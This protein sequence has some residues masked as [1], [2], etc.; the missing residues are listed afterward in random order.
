MKK[1][2]APSQKNQKKPGITLLSSIVVSGIILTLV[3]SFMQIILKDI[4]LNADFFEGEKSYFAAESGIEHGLLALKT[5]P[6]QNINQTIELQAATAQINVDNITTSEVLTI[7]SLGNVKLSL[8]IAKG[9][10]FFPVELKNLQATISKEVGA[11]AVPKKNVI[12]WKLQCRQENQTISIQGTQDRSEIAQNVFDWRGIYDTPTEKKK[13]YRLGVFW[14]NLS[15]DSVVQ[16][17]CFLSFQNLIDQPLKISLSGNF[18]PT[19]APITSIGRAN[20]RQ[21]I[22]RFEI[23]QKSLSTLFDFG[24]FDD[25]QVSG[26]CATLNDTP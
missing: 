3:L 9:A 2:F 4:Q 22:I 25:C 13:N 14:N 26:N 15:S 23:A 18:P 17:S 19:L 6:T 11:V 7:A 20:N 21:K 8:K 24:I 16:A 12:Q 5:T 10:T 1:N